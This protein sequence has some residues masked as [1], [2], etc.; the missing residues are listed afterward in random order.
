MNFQ[1]QLE[2]LK[3]FGWPQKEFVVVSSGALAVR[4]IRDSHDLDVMVSKILWNELSKKYPTVKNEY[5]IERLCPD[6]EIEIFHPE[7][8]IFGD[9]GG[10]LQTQEVFERADLLEEIQ[11][12]N[13][14]DLKLIK[15]KM[16]REKDLR[17]I[18][19]IDTYLET[20]NAVTAVL[21]R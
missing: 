9:A 8:T 16:G 18:E 21:P 2:K 3:S 13:L 15:T 5:G 6:P 11:F 7:H 14:R 4:G 19:L 12:M 1:R 20:E 17:D 10:I